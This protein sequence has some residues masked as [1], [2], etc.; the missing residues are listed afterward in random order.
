MNYRKKLIEV[1][2]PLD[3]INRE[4]AREKS[5]RHGHP[6]TLHL[7]WARRPLAACRAVLFASLVDD[8]SNR[9][10][11]TEAEQERE[12][13]NL[14]ELIK[15]LVKWENINNEQ[16]LEKARAEILKSTNG[17]PPPV[18]DPFCG[19]GSIP[20]EAQRLGLEAYGSDLNPVA[21]LITKAMIEI[22][23]RFAGQPPVNPDAQSDSLQSQTWKGAT[24][25]AEDV[26][27]YGKW[28]RKEAEKRIGHLYPKAKLPEEQGGGEAT[29][30]A[31]VWAR[32]AKCHNPACEAKMPLVTTFWLSKRRRNKAWIEPTVDKA[33]KTVRFEVKTGDGTPPAPTKIGRGAR[34]RC[35]VCCQDSREEYIKSESMEGR[36]DTQLMGIVAEGQNGQIYLSPSEKHEKIAES[37]NPNWAPEIEMNRD[38]STLVSGRGYGF[39]TWADL[40]TQRQLTALTTFSDLISE[41]RE[42][43][44]MDANNADCEKTEDYADAVVTYLAFALDKGADY[45]SNL[46]RWV[47]RGGYMGHTLDRQAIAMVWDYAECNPFSQSTGNWLACVE[48][49]ARFINKNFGNIRVRNGHVTQLDAA[50]ALLEVDAPLISTDPPYYDNIDYAELS[51]FFYIWLRRSLRQIYPDLFRL[52]LVPTVEELVAAR[53]RFGGDRRRAEEHFLTGLSKAFQ[54]MKDR[55]HPDYPVTV[56]YAFKQSE[57]DSNNG[58][59]ASTGWETM[60]EGL[61]KAG[62]QIT[63]TLP[64]RTE[65][66][67]RQIAMGTN[68]LASSI[69]LVCRPRSDEASMT[70]RRGFIAALRR[71]LPDALHHLQQGNIAPVDLAQAAI[72]PGMAVFSNYSSVLEPDGSP[73]RVRTALQIINAELDAHFT[74]QEGDLD[75][76]TRFCVSWFEQYGMREAPFGDA[77]VLARA[78]DTS[79]EG[80]AESGVLRAR[81]GRV[82]LLSREEYPD[83]WDPTSDRRVNTW[84]CTQYLIRALDRGGEVEVA[85]LANQLSSEQVENA[86]ALAYRLFAICERKGWAQ[87]AIAYNRLITSWTHIQEARKGSEVRETQ[88]TFDIE[89]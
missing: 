33:N 34:F 54:F 40:F 28:M 35:L 14:F 6:S 57:T 13:E 78:R 3:D 12:R 11:L 53:H 30:I 15:E 25:L 49:G 60:L 31:W 43:I 1:A 61:L 76:D 51:N 8:P 62:F 41:A 58:S 50:A 74:E 36:V 79:V 72:G 46:C 20:L 83:E 29:V 59:V 9:D 77:E 80:V 69:V 89:E 73:M 2:L 86:R 47:S 52:M 65:M 67:S 55:A 75:L 45:W 88:Q 21:V 68:A 66:K 42:K 70:T 18:L 48:W 4:A 84:E 63:G 17:N 23:P 56:Y 87:E 81:A 22:P 19:G 37:A 38:T 24:G 26:R 27:Y 5:I 44:K 32:R 64:M 85:R 71:D 7:W 10:D 82:R 16:V 39:Y